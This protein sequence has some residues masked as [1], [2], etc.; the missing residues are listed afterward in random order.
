MESSPGP[1]L[2]VGR[3]CLHGVDRFTRRFPDTFADTLCRFLDRRLRVNGAG[4]YTD[5][6]DMQFFE[7]FVG[8]FG[9][10]R[11]VSNIDRVDISG[12]ELGADW[13]K[14]PYAEGFRKV[15]DACYKPVVIM[16]GSRRGSEA[17]I[18][19]EVRAAMDAGAAGATI[20]RNIFEADDPEAM[21]AAGMEPRELKREFGREIAFWGGGVETQEV[22]PRGTPADVADAG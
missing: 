15:T 18:L 10:L 8:T 4:Y 1:R 5:V 19:A 14:V 17:E 6:S 16:G 9:L 3:G 2:Y 12:V 7:F 20:G 13:V 11:V 22:L 21:T